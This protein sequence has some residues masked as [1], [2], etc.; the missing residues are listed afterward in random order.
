MAPPSHANAVNK[1]LQSRAL[2][3]DAA[4]FRQEMLSPKMLGD[5]KLHIKLYR[6]IWGQRVSHKRTHTCEGT[7]TLAAAAQQVPRS[8]RQNTTLNS[9]SCGKNRH[10][11]DTVTLHTLVL[12]PVS[13]CHLQFHIFMWFVHRQRKLSLIF[14][15]K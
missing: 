6:G 15:L 9:D 13:G 3:L 5:S 8:L 7:H 1:E 14:P 11:Q 10:Q 4:V 2:G 12:V